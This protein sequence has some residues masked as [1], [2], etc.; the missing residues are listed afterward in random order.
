MA[1]EYE[2]DYWPCMESS[3]DAFMAMQT[4]WR[5]GPA[6]PYGFDYSALQTVYKS[7]SI[8][9]K[10]RPDVF[11]DIRV[12]EAAAIKEMRRK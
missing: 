5:V 7:L 12:M 1:A 6:G 4:Q 2:A 8:A 10:K 3:V 9:S 11:E